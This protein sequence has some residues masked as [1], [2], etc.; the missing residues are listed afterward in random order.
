MQRERERE[1]DT[2]ETELQF[3]FWHR[4]RIVGKPRKPKMGSL[5]AGTNVSAV[6]W[7]PIYGEAFRNGESALSSSGT[8]FPASAL[9]G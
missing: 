4:G 8:A 6:A 5:G 3:V 7:N 1:R 2:R 9:L